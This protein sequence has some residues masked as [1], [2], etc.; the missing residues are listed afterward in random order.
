MALMQ[1]YHA[2]DR[3]GRY[4]DASDL[5]KLSGILGI[6]FSQIPDQAMKF[7]KVAGIRASG[8]RSFDGL[9]DYYYQSQ[10]GSAAKLEGWLLL[11][12]AYKEFSVDPGK[13]WEFVRFEGE[14][15][16]DNPLVCY[17]SALSSLKAGYNEE[18]I[19]LLEEGMRGSSGVLFPAWNYQLGRCYLNRLD[20][21][22]ADYLDAFLEAAGG[23]TYRHIGSL[24]LA[25]H[26][27]I[28]GESD[29]AKLMFQKIKQ[30]PD[31]KSVYDKHAFREAESKILPDAGLIRL[32]L[33]FDG[34]YFEQCLAGCAQLEKKGIL[35]GESETELIYRKARCLQR[36][37]RTDPAIDCYLRVL[38]QKRKV[39]NYWLPNSALQ[40]GYLYKEK[41][42]TD[43]AQKYFE[44]CLDLNNYGYREG[45]RRQAQAALLELED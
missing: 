8:L 35:T 24:R 4:T 43:L 29:Q 3:Y 5:N 41:G 15:F 39:K 26:Y 13:S 32:R 34:G 19:R 36:L 2:I 30:L 6:L 22:A 31:A 37:N 20:P 42:Q 7:L 38:D 12:T 9:R 1:A 25:W 16:P 44:I 40:L 23:E 11:V 33:L 45:I 14:L 10:P 17:Q 28:N 18:A 21:K 27:L